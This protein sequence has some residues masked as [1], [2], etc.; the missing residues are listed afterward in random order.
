MTNWRF[1]THKMDIIKMNYLKKYE[2]LHGVLNSFKFILTQLEALVRVLVQFLISSE[3]KSFYCN[4]IEFLFH[5]QDG[6]HHIHHTRWVRRCANRCDLV[7]DLYE[8]DAIE[9]GFCE[10]QK[11]RNKHASRSHGKSC[12]RHGKSICLVLH[13]RWISIQRQ[14]KTVWHGWEAR[15][16]FGAFWFHFTHRRCCQRIG[17]HFG[18]VIDAWSKRIVWQ[19]TETIEPL[20]DARW[21]VRI[22]IPR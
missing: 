13:S 22:L 7:I 10:N 12:N 3:I 4:W 19:C 16:W 18:R 2:T 1:L 5:F 21:N 9:R 14:Q 11:H 8:M 20:A 17:L 15:F 6:I